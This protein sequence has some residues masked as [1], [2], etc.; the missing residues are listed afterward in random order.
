MRP[1]HSSGQQWEHTQH[2]FRNIRRTTHTHTHASTHIFGSPPRR[3]AETLPHPP[4]PSFLFRFAA[5]HARPA[6]VLPTSDPLQLIH[7]A[8]SLYLLLRLIYLRSIFPQP[9]PSSSRPVFLSDADAQ[10]PCPREPWKAPPGAEST[11]CG[12]D[13][14]PSLGWVLLSLRVLIEETRN[15]EANKLHAPSPC[16]AGVPYI[17]P[18]HRSG[19]RSGRAFD[20]PGEGICSSGTDLLPSP[21]RTIPPGALSLPR[22]D[23]LRA[24]SQ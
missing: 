19:T 1:N 20:L 3:V 24:F 18:R 8:V 17:G 23:L 5:R 10:K 9:P 13:R 22:V 7:P 15:I 4:P 12:G 14:A 21:P 16:H 2:I 6:L 11:E